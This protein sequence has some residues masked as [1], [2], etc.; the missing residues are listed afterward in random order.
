MKEFF[1]HVVLVAPEIPQ[2][3][4]NIGRICSC[5][6][7]RL[8]LVKPLGFSLDDRHVKRSGMDYWRHVEYT[9]HESWEDFVKAMDGAPMYFYS[10]KGK[11]VYWDCPMEDGS[12]LIFGSEG[13]GLP[14]AIHEAWPEQ[15]YTIPMPGHFSRSLNLANS[16][17]V[18]VY[19]G[20]RRRGD[21]IAEQRCPG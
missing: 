3:T 18:A 11:K 13:S 8:H 9:I 17:A 21:R 1:F 16:V 19:E 5:T 20:L 6:R 2:N 15:F 10:T 7:C 4:G 14:A 12:C